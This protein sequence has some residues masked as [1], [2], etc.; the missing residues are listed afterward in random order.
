VTGTRIAFG[1]KVKAGDVD[2]AYRRYAGFYDRVFGEL[3]ERGRSAAARAAIATG[4]RRVL[5]VGVGTGLSLH[6]Y[7]DT[8]RVTGIDISEAMLERARRKVAE[9]GLTNVEALSIMDAEATSFADD[10]FD[11]VVCMYVVSC[12]PS[13]EGLMQE[14]RRICAPGGRVI[15]VNH[16]AYGNPFLN[17]VE[18]FLSIFARWLGFKPD[19]PLAQVERAAAMERVSVTKVDAGGFWHVVDLRNTK[20]VGTPAQAAD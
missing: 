20:A 16:F 4:G 5:E 3:F 6:Y 14:I 10:S 1:S 18:K 13:V 19:T 17:G 8:M 12:V 9:R 11:T 2:K 15:I 7:P